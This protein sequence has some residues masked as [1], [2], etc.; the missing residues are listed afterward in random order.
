MS[1]SA[2][3]RKDEHHQIKDWIPVALLSFMLALCGQQM[4]CSSGFIGC[5]WAAWELT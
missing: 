5:C 4:L 3:E 1:M 2:L